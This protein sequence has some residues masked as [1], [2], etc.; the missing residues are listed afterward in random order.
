MFWIHTCSIA[1]EAVKTEQDSNK[2]IFTSEKPSGQMI[3]PESKFMYLLWFQ[4]DKGF[5]LKV[6]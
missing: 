5:M 2:C 6:H 4:S 1:R 3:T